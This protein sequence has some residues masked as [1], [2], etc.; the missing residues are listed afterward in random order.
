[1]DGTVPLNIGL[2][3]IVLFLMGA[4]IAAA[5]PACNNPIFAEIVPP[6]LRNMVRAWSGRAV[7]PSSRL[8]SLHLAEEALPSCWAI[9]H[10]CAHVLC[11]DL[12]RLCQQS[13]TASGLR[14]CAMPSICRGFASACASTPHAA[15]CSWGDVSPCCKRMVAPCGL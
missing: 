11:P 9:E 1:M 3:A 10:A 12:V 6:E 4:C 15:L 13:C 7:A 14:T 2:Y 5:A 8:G